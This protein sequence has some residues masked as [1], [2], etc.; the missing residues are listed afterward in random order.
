VKSTKRVQAVMSV[1][2]R[3]THFGAFDFDP[4]GQ[5]VF[6]SPMLAQDAAIVPA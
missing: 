1:F 3:V 5:A 2:S 6:V 4:L